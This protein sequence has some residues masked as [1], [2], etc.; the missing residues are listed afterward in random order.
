MLRTS[1]SVSAAGCSPL[2]RILRT[3]MFMAS[4]FRASMPKAAVLNPQKRDFVARTLP[5]G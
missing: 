5:H 2:G 3:S 1:V 4:M